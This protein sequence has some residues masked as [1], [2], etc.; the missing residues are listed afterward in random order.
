MMQLEG[1]WRCADTDGFYHDLEENKARR[2]HMLDSEWFTTDHMA[3]LAVFSLKAKMRYSAKLGINLR[4]WRPDD[5]LQ[6][7]AAETSTD[8]KIGM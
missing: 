8:G 4:S 5:S 6:R 2:V 3:V 1:S 7:A